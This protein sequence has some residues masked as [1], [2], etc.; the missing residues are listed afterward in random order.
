MRM[1]AV[2]QRHF[3]PGTAIQTGIRMIVQATPLPSRVRSRILSCPGCNRRVNTID[4]RW[5]KLFGRN[6]T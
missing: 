6:E 3:R 5:A 4:R 2:Y 1:K